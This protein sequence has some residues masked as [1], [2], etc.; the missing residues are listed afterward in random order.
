M[1]F[2]SFPNL[3]ILHVTKKNVSKILEERMVEAYRMGY[4]YG[5]FIH[6]DIDNLQGE[7]RMPR[8]VTGR[9]VCL[10]CARERDVYSNGHSDHLLRL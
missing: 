8:E 9:C 7:V 1:S 5:V 4:N 10:K 3:G 2:C 6:P